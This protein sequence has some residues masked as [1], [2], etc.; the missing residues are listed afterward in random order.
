MPNT[1]LE[2]MSVGLPVFATKYTN[3]TKILNKNRCGW[4]ISHKKNNISNF[5]L[6]LE[7]NNKKKLYQY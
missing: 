3:V 6:D 7:D 1:V 4:E 5:L 2:A